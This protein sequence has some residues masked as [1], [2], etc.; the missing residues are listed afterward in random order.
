MLARRSWL[1]SALAGLSACAFQLQPSAGGDGGVEVDAR[2]VD[3]PGPLPGA[4]IAYWRFDVDGR[5]HLGSHDGAIVGAA[6][7][8]SGQVGRRGEALRITGSGGRVDIG[9]PVTFNFN[10]DFTWHIYVRTSAASGALFSRNPKAM[11]W[12]QGSKAMFVRSDTVQWDT[13]WVSN[14]NTTARVDDDEWHQVIARYVAATDRLDVFVDPEIGATQG[15]YTGTHN[16]NAFDEHAHVHLSGLAETGFSIGAANFTGGL[17]D[18]GSLIGF[19]D[20]AAVFDYA[21]SGSELARLI[22]LGPAGFF[23]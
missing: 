13:G 17:S 6:A 4:P 11:A 23:P 1:G 10:A 16:V 8:T 18:L 3:A 7:I 19:L 5:D 12:N 22:E 21:S 2:D 14:P 9:M 15:R 20:E